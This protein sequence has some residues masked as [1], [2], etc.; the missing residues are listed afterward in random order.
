MFDIQI[1]LNILTYPWIPR[2]NCIKQWS[3]I[4]MSKDIGLHLTYINSAVCRE[5]G[6]WKKKKREMIRH[7]EKKEIKY[8]ILD[9]ASDSTYHSM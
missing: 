6:W 4:H 2:I 5:R 8:K 3:S 1:D 7:K 9:V